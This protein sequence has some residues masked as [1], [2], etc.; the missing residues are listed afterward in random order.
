MRRVRVNVHNVVTNIIIEERNDANISVINN[1][2][3]EQ[4]TK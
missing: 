2:F 1:V 3:A 4:E